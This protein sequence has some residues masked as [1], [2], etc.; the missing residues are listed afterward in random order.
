MKRE[1]ILADLLKLELLKIRYLGAY[2]LLANNMKQFLTS[3]EDSSSRGAFITYI[4]D[5]TGQA[6]FSR[7]L[8]DHFNEVS[9]SEHQIGDVMR[10]INYIFCKQ[11]PVIPKSIVS[12]TGIRRYFHY[13]L[14]NGNLSQI[15][16]DNLRDDKSDSNYWSYIKNNISNTFELKGILD[17]VFYKDDNDYKRILCS[18]LYVASCA[19]EKDRSGFLNL[20]VRMVMDK[21]FKIFVDHLD[22]ETEDEIYNDIGKGYMNLL[23]SRWFNEPE[24]L[25]SESKIPFLTL[26]AKKWFNIFA[27]NI[28]Q[29][30]GPDLTQDSDL[31][32]SSAGPIDRKLYN[33]KP[34]ISKTFHVW[35]KFEL[36]INELDETQSKSLKEFKDFYQKL[37]EADFKDIEYNFKVNVVFKD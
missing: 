15:E 20:I 9:V 18:L 4:R 7:Y 19:N 25:K 6:A 22:E 2:E 13:A 11:S 27:K 5:G 12:P 14:L 3:D 26:C 8:Y 37:K 17:V 36:F 32:F 21:R 1:I 30:N 10:Y 35:D 23:M 33:I 34:V 28:I 16:F 31:S 24:L 29:I